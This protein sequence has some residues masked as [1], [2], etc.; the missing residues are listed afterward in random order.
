MN[1]DRLVEFFSDE[2]KEL[3]H[4]IRLYISKGEKLNI[5][6][7]SINRIENS[8]FFLARSGNEKNL[9]PAGGQMR[10]P[11]LGEPGACVT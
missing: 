4:L 6:P 7:R 10:L 8:Y 5:Y 2:S 3:N 9:Y 11:T 1:K